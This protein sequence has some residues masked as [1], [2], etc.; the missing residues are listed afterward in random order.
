MAGRPRIVVASPYLAECETLA[1][2]LSSDGFDPIRAATCADAANEFQ[3]CKFD[4]LIADAAFAFRDGLDAAARTQ[5]RNPQT[6]TV[7]IGDSTAA[8]LH[9][10]LKGAM[11]LCRPV[12]RAT[13][14]CTVSMALMEER[15]IRRSLRKPV[16]RIPAVVDGVASHIIDVSAEGLRLEIPRDRRSSLPPY[17]NVR[18][19]LIGVSLMVQRMW[20]IAQPGQATTGVAWYGG[21]LSRNSVK[22]EAAWYRFVDTIPGLRRTS[23]GAPSA[24]PR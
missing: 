5:R 15:P 8:Q 24:R 11:Y 1:D 20:G 7:V 4:L 2:W 6:P 12:E 22:A 18:V 23:P 16:N 17:F 14:T 21:A 9:A 19:P 13:L 10:D 3:A